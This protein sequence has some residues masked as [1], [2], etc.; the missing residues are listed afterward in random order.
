MND[1]KS[2]TYQISHDPIIRFCAFYALLYLGSLILGGVGVFLIVFGAMIIFTRILVRFPY[3]QSYY[4]K[5]FGFPFNQA[6]QPANKPRSRISSALTG[7]VHLL[8]M[9]IYAA[10][11]IFVMKMGIET[12]LDNGFLNQNLIY[13]LFLK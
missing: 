12:L 7:A 8:I 3:F 9:G 2:S 1:S 6:E 5:F 10:L 11:S 13:L 4:R